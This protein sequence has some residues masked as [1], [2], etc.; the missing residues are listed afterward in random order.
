[1]G[2][3]IPTPLEPPHVLMEPVLPH[4]ACVVVFTHQKSPDKF[5]LLT[6]ISLGSRVSLFFENHAGI[7]SVANV[8]EAPTIAFTYN[9][10][11]AIVSRPLW[12]CGRTL[13]FRR[14]AHN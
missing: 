14:T 6:L 5:D 10:S 11:I 2:Q 3:T 12:K 1:M 4:K 8:P 13:T 7:L 9:G